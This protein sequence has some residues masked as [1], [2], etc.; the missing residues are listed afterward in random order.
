MILRLSSCLI[1]SS[2]LEFRSAVVWLHKQEKQRRWHQRCALFRRGCQSPWYVEQRLSA[3]GTKRRH[4]FST[5]GIQRENWT[6][7]LVETVVKST[8]WTKTYKFTRRNQGDWATIICTWECRS[9]YT[10]ADEPRSKRLY[11]R[12]WVWP[13]EPNSGQ[14]KRQC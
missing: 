1:L 12:L 9:P 5:S 10:R 14:V 6:N 8:V 7:E 3:N 13:T 11:A 2:I 4:G